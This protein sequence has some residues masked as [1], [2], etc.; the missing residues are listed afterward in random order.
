M[1][2]TNGAKRGLRAGIVGAGFGGVGAA[3]KLREAGVENL[4][5]F[6]RGDSVGGVWRANTYPG[7]ACDIPSH[8]YSFSFA[9]GHHWSRRYAPQAEILTYLDDCVR[10]FGIGPDLRLNTEVAEARFDAESGTWTVRTDAGE[11]HKFDVLVTACGQL[12]RP[13]IPPLAGIDDFAGP[14]F[15][16]AEW[17]HDLD[18]S[19][20]KVAVVG[21]G[22]SAIQFVPEI[23]KVAAS[24]TIYQRSAPWILPKSDRGY[25][26]WE[27]RLFRRFP[28]R[29]AASRLGLFA[30]FEMGTYGFTGHDSVLGPVRKV[31]DWERNRQ[32]GDDPEL[33]AKA[34]PDYEIG[35][36]RV[37]FTNDWYPA[38]VRDDVELVTGSIERVTAGAI[39]AA[40]GVE[41]EADVIIYGTGFQSHNFVA[42][43]DVY[44]LGGQELNAFWAERPEA[45]LGTTVSGF[46]NMFVLYG[47]NTNHGSGSV[48]YTLE[49]QF[50]YVVD[51]VR[52]LR[53]GGFR[54]IDLRPETQAAW[55]R[56]IA[57]RSADTVW[58][59]GGCTN[60][61]VNGR[62]ENTNNWPG[63]WLE[64][65]RR[66]KRIN[67]GDYRVAA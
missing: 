59:T 64:Y 26:E 34:T 67:P 10:D 47:P 7:A 1:S 40:D 3:I 2:S 36:K 15:H 49:S 43:M 8:L 17:D 12:T 16:S 46:P 61:Y 66:T 20:L 53:D 41:R 45:Y 35:C 42:P 5:L 13:S 57:E 48:P 37:L 9:P 14:V 62:G 27:R 60:W 11:S 65:R 24:T 44:G 22:A 6:E 30:F 21:T 33:L 50:S 52:R 19:G 55:R 28:L 29:V 38:L 39:A 25:P 32:L 63:P 31:A 51:A 23:A 54:W 58:T 56:E 18:L 4:T